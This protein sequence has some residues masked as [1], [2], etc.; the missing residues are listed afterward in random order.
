MHARGGRRPSRDL[1][2]RQSGAAAEDDNAGDDAAELG[3]IHHILHGRH[4][5]LLDG[6][7]IALPALHAG[8]DTR[9]GHSRRPHPPS[10]QGDYRSTEEAS[11]LPLPTPE[12]QR[13]QRKGCRWLCVLRQGSMGEIQPPRDDE[14]LS[15]VV[16]RRT[17]GLTQSDVERASPS[18]GFDPARAGVLRYR[19][20]EP[21]AWSACPVL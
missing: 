18:A 5:S 6:M 3:A 19:S 12:S 11:A 7:D 17:H 10:R 21:D 8:S 16:V 1:S 13:R 14:S 20:K 9:T 2:L 4:Q 15:S